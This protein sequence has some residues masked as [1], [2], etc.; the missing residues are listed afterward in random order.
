MKPNRSRFTKNH[1]VFY[2]AVGQEPA[3]PYFSQASQVITHGE[4]VYDGGNGRQNRLCPDQVTGPG[5]HRTFGKPGAE[6]RQDRA[7]NQTRHRKDAC[8][9]APFFPWLVAASERAKI[10][11]D[12]NAQGQRKE[13]G[14]ERNENSRNVLSEKI[15]NPASWSHRDERPGLAFE[16]AVHIGCCP[17]Q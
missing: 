1:V 7:V 5:H 9:Y 12:Q 13:C 11:G 10:V 3:Q 17:Q 16:F 2:L 6:H 8:Q 15:R 4:L 14:Q